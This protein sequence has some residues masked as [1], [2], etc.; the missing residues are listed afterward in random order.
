MPPPAAAEL[1]GS[2]Y[3]PCGDRS[4][5]VEIVDCIGAMTKSWDQR[6][7][8]AYKNLTQRIDAG[9][10]EPLKA[11]QRLWVQYR[12]A[13]WRFY[14]S[15]DGTIRQIQAAECMR[16]LTQDRALELEKAMKFD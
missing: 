9:Q 2:D 15:Q 6:L 8:T 12:D 4:N 16:T 13:N 5:T 3:A 10:R 14:A 7:N 11:A 1:F